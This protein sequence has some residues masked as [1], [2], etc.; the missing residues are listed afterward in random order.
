M[1]KRTRGNGTGTAFKRGKTWT[2]Q[3]TKYMFRDENGRLV[4]RYATKGGFSTKRDAL[5]YIATLKA[6]ENR[7]VT[8]FLELYQ[9]W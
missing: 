6:G 1:K 5:E 9:T 4:R 7:R 3:Y 2:A 8:T